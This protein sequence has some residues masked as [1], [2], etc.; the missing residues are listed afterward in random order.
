MADS[1]YVPQV[2][3]TSRDYTGIKTDLLNLINVFT[4]EWTTRDPSDFGITLIELFS[5]MGDMLSYYIDRSA[6]ESFLYSATQRENVLRIASMLGYRPTGVTS[7]TTTVSIYNKNGTSV[8]VLAG[9][10]LA[11]NTV[12]N[13]TTPQI[14]FETD[15]DLTISAGATATVTAHQG[16]TYTETLTLSASGLPNQMYKLTNPNVVISALSVTVGG[17]P[18]TIVDNIIDHSGYVPVAETYTDADGYTYVIFG[19]NVSGRIPPA[20]SAITATYRTASGT[21]GNIAALTPLS[22]IKVPSGSIPTNI[23][24]ATTVAATGGGDAE[25]TDS[26]R[27]SAP[28]SL[29]ALNRAVSLSDYAALTV[30]VDGVD[31]AT[32]VGNTYNSV[33][34]YFVPTGDTGLSGSNPSTVFTTVAAAVSAYLVDKIPPT[35]TVTFQPPTYVKSNLIANVTLYPTYKQSQ[36]L[37]AI[38]VALADLFSSAKVNFQQTIGVADLYRTLQLIPGVAYAQVVK[39][40]RDDLDNVKSVT[41]K[42]L[43]SNV[44]T[45]TVGSGHGFTVGQTISVTGVDSTFNGTF[46]IT[47]TASTTI[48]YALV[49]TNVVSAAATGTV[50]LLVVNDILTDANEIAILNPDTTKVVTNISGGIS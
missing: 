26:I 4:P 48:S 3:Y 40:V 6:N 37:T 22:V 10:Q 25:S 23:T 31:K 38:N 35:T 43:T 13:S 47:A 16:V 41:N 44:A 9:T 15:S 34:V 14:I 39:L 12:V 32:A 5:Y 20:T 24:I 11:A 19:N 49:A 50:S 33:T 8:T 42:A 30:L 36:V 21:L 18:Y 28:N 7:A 29:T 27:V 46:V 2:D 17:I 1:N 45:L